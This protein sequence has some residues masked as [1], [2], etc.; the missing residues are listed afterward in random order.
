MERP[1]KENKSVWS[2]CWPRQINI[3]S[4]NSPAP[5]TKQVIVFPLTPSLPVFNREQGAKALSLQQILNWLYLTSD[6][7]EKNFTDATVQQ[8]HDKKKPVTVH[9]QSQHCFLQLSSCINVIT[10]WHIYK[11]YTPNPLIQ[12][13]FIL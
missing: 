11:Y 1:W 12:I 5:L 3:L 4:H 8:L 9:S 6:E 7:A 10:Q 2:L 13:L